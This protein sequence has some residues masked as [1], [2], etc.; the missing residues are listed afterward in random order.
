MRPDQ[1]QPRLFDD[2]GPQVGPE[3]QEARL[4]RLNRQRQMAWRRR[5]Q[6]A[7][8]LIESPS[9]GTYQTGMTSEDD[10]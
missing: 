2:D 1:H 6:F 9:G 5:H 10:E 8:P 4:R 7:P 3:P